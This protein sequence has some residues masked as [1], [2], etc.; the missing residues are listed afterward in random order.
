MNKTHQRFRR[1]VLS[2]AAVLALSPPAFA[3]D[4]VFTTGPYAGPATI[5]AGDVLN[6]DPGSY[7]YLNSG[8]TN[9]GTV[10]ASDDLYF[11]NGNVL[12]NNGLFDWKV[13]AGF[14]DGG[15]NGG[16]VNSGTLRKSGG[17]GTS[18]VSI[19]GFTSSGTIDAQT[20]T[21][22]FNAGA[23]FNAG[24]AF[25][26]AGQIVV[27]NGA[28]FTGAFGSRNLTLANGSFSGSAAQISG[29]VA[30]TGGTLTGSWALAAGQ[31]LAL[32]AGNYKNL[33]ASFANAGTMA[34][35][36]NLFFQNG[37]M[38][39]NTG[40]FDMQGDVGLYDGGSNGGLTNN[41]TLRKSSGTGT[42]YVSINHFVNNGTVNA[43][44][45]TINFNA[46]GVFNAGTA[47]TGAGQ[48]VV[49][50]GASFN[51]A[52][53]TAGNLVLA[54]GAY[55]GNGAKI[56]GNTQW[57][58]GTL[59]GDWTVQATRTLRVDA[60][61]YK[62]LNGSLSNQ[63][64]IAATD[65]LYF[66][67]GNTLT[68]TG[69][70][71]VR[72]D[73]GLYDGGSNGSFVNNGTFR[74]SVGTGTT[75]VS[76]NGFS[77]NG[78]IDAQT[79]TISFNTGAVFNAGTAFTGA[80]QV[81][82]SNGATF[83]GA[84]TTAG[85]LT[86]AAGGYTGNA[87]KIDGDLAWTAGSLTGSWEVAAGRTLSTS[88]GGYKYV[89]GGLVNNGTIGAGDDLYLQNGNVLTNNGA[90]LAKGDVGLADGG[91]NGSF[92]NNGTFRKTAGGGTTSVSI[93]GFSNNGTVE[94]QAGTINFNAGA[95]FNAGT[96]FTGAGR[97]VV[98]NGANFSGA[99]TTADNLL[100]TGGQYNGSSSAP[101]TLAAGSA[102]VTAGTLAGHWQT[103][104]GT[105][106]NLAAGS[107]KYVNG[108]VTNGGT[109]VATDDLYLQN[110][111][112]LTNSGVYQ[113]KGDVGIY[114]GGS[115]GHFVNNGS[116]LKD[117]G[118]GSTNV[119][120]IDFQN[121]GTVDVRSGTIV[122]PTNFSN[123]GTVTGSGA[124]AT[125]LLTNSGHVAPGT[126]AG[127]L[128]L[129][130][131][132]AQTAAG[133]M[134]IELASSGLF[135]LFAING[136]ASLHGALALSCI[137]GCD[138]HTGDIFTFLDSTGDLTGTFDSVTTAGFL[139]G[140]DYSVVYDYDADLVKLMVL[141]AG[142]AVPPIP[143]PVPEPGTWALMFAGLGVIG[144]V[145]RRRKPRG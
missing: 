133:S 74:K 115:N 140:F 47:F 33:N 128:T 138:I 69:L 97:V 80:G 2:T 36:D 105:T 45:G 96:A 67:N 17:T 63:G 103:A 11:Q 34:L 88:A 6:V 81:V 26:G 16:F 35:T 75:N 94:A 62:Y 42:S 123:P 31:T 22:A 41:A 137:A 10:K 109:V 141:D 49:S 136:T 106:L 110:G 91:S 142:A 90:Y 59:T 53:T 101:A 58:A 73:A 13:D 120:G 70:F 104:A 107:Y 130:G 113:A 32:G 124:L 143:A 112:T 30:W 93:N 24:S 8:L 72:A 1:H 25:T 23:T 76:I 3:V 7:K 55:A 44:T 84:F 43:Q 60:G 131:D 89:N 61:S 46:G 29:N 5:G 64:T 68:N 37:K 28:G 48:I 100:L 51:G 121:A 118:T 52:L 19:N 12:T 77:N 116:F 126:G 144:A 85:N 125:N 38:L 79:G 122:L 134:D 39:S 50:N 40:V 111:N 145:A 9:N 98:S 83:N 139:N 129:N 21:I 78:T 14:Y 86:L 132:F 54:A 20:G 117:V 15:S 71:E 114:D 99:F 66:Q 65:D 135:D 87:A 119:A 95:A 108:S 27:T 127:T 4:I 82:V 57:T 102:T 56:D 18:Y 92:V